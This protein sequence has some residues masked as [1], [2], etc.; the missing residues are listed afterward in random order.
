MPSEGAATSA[1]GGRECPQG[2]IHTSV[3]VGE[4]AAILHSFGGLVPESERAATLG[5]GEA[6]IGTIS[7]AS[8]VPQ[9]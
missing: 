9:V 7:D 5:A 4:V 2:P 8:N 3:E 6:A 1:V